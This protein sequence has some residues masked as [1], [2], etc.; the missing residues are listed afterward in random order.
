MAAA[1]SGISHMWRDL[2]ANNRFVRTARDA[3]ARFSS[4]R[5]LMLG[6]GIAFNSAFSLAPALLIVLAVAGWFFGADAAQGRLFAEVKN[7][8]GQAVVGVFALSIAFAALI[9]WLPDTPVRFGHAVIGAFVAALLFTI[10]RQLFGFYLAHTG[11]VSTFGAA[12]S[13]AVLMMWLYFSAAV[14]L[15]GSEVTAAIRSNA[16]QRTSRGSAAA[17]R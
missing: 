12:G 17:A 16:E 13:L 11:T 4:D 6:S 3:I 8:I 15:L 5:C 14:F 9:K 10:G 2:S 1:L 7:V